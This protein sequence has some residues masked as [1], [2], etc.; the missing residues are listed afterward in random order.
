M[1]RGRFSGLVWLVWIGLDG[2]VWL[3]L[4]RDHAICEG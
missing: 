2:G 1:W 4:M 3:V